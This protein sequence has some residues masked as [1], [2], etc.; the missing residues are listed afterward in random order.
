MIFCWFLLVLCGWCYYYGALLSPSLMG[1]NARYQNLVKIKRLF[2]TYQ[3]PRPPNSISNLVGDPWTPKLR[4]PVLG[5][6]HHL[7]LASRRGWNQTCFLK[8]QSPEVTHT[9]SSQ[10][11]LVEPVTWPHIAARDSGTCSPSLG[12]CSP[13][14]LFA[15][16][17]L[18]AFCNRNIELSHV[19]WSFTRGPSLVYTAAQWCH[20]RGLSSFPV[21]LLSIGAFYPLTCYPMAPR[22]LLSTPSCPR[23][24]KKWKAATSKCTWCI[25][26]F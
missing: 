25:S 13:Q 9:T 4:I 26:F 20:P 14:P 18:V 3:V 15:T 23:D 5:P 22:W 12:S 11:F 2:L 24:E 16:L 21:S 6:Y 19:M 8:I 17:F 7:H 1:G 10:I